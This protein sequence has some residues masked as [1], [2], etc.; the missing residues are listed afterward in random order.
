MAQVAKERAPRASFLQRHATS[1]AVR[2][3]LHSY[4][5]VV[6]QVRRVTN[7]RRKGASTEQGLGA[8]PQGTGG[9]GPQ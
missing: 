5:K 7:P 8:R 2:A 3:S 1:K 6:D 4:R 9:E